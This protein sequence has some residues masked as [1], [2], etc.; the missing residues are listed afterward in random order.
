MLQ[1][2]QTKKVIFWL[3]H[4]HLLHSSLDRPAWWDCSSSSAPDSWHFLLSCVEHCA[5]F[6]FQPN[7]EGTLMKMSMSGEGH[8]KVKQK[9]LTRDSWCVTNRTVSA[10]KLNI[11]N[12]DKESFG[13]FASDVFSQWVSYRSDHLNEPAMVRKRCF[14]HKLRVGCG[15]VTSVTGH[16]LCPSN[17]V[18]NVKQNVPGCSLEASLSKQT[19]SWGG[20]WKQTTTRTAPAIVS[21]SLNPGYSGCS[22]SY[23]IFGG[24]SVPSGGGEKTVANPICINYAEICWPRHILTDWEVLIDGGNFAWHKVQC[25]VDRRWL[26]G[27]HNSVAKVWFQTDPNLV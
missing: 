8:R 9:G 3:N 25:S 5:H 1:G 20:E 23:S 15:D 19:V 12:L 22:G 4:I 21:T 2:E 26:R 14:L 7:F 18:S 10:K 13:V 11:S 24:M 17:I 6:H 16:V 27:V